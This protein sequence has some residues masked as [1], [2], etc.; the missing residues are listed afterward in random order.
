MP[1]KPRESCKL[2]EKLKRGPDEVNDRVGKPWHFFLPEGQSHGVAY[3]KI[4][5]STT[6][7][8]AS[9]ILQ[10]GDPSSWSFEPDLPKGNVWGVVT[11]RIVLALPNTLAEPQLQEGDVVHEPAS[12]SATDTATLPGDSSEPGTQI[13]QMST[14][15]Y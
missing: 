4:F 7:F 6:Q 14:V 1:L 3:L 9:S 5:F 13:I 11:K 12:S 10:T 8:N 2:G 15:Y